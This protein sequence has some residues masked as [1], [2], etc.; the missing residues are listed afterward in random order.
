MSKE[1]AAAAGGAAAPATS[2]AAA[3]PAASHF[4]T[5][6]GPAP[7]SE[8]DAIEAA[9]E[10]SFGGDPARKGASAAAA[11]AKN[12]TLSTF[13]LLLQHH[14]W[15]GADYSR[16]SC[17]ASLLQL[18]FRRDRASAAE[19]AR[20]V[21]DQRRRQRQ[22]QEGSS[23]NILERSIHK[24]RS[25]GGSRS[26]CADTL[27]LS[28]LLTRASCMCARWHQRSA[29]RWC[30][31]QSGHTAANRRAGPTKRDCAHGA[32]LLQQ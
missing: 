11:D 4:A 13:A 12:A 18:L 7:V 31:E 1:A 17:S 25:D 8:K 30:L 22:G 16:R 23:S 32:L 14:P 27:L 3:A 6:T 5:R 19:G 20:A 29:G 21:C 9:I 24:R 15:T 10:A 26:I 28:V 2:T